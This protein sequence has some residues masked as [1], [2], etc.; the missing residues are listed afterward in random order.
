MARNIEIRLIRRRLRGAYI[1]T[2]VSISLVLFILGIMGLLILNARKLSNYVKENIGFSVILNDNSKEADVKALQKNLDAA[3][4]VKSTEY[5]S[6]EKA[7]EDLQ[8]ELDE[9]FI[10]FLGFNPLL[11]SINVHLFAD[12]ANPD[13][14]KSIEKNFQ[15]YPQ[16]KEV[17]YQKNLLHLINENVR[18]I[19]MILLLF[20]TLLFIISFTLINNT[21]RLVVYSKRFII[22]TMRLVGATSGFIRKPFIIRGVLQGLLGAILAFSM[23]LAFIF[24]ANNEM[25]DISSLIDGQII[26]ILFFLVII[27]GIL[28]TGISTYFAVNRYIK[29]NTDE[30]YY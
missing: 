25:K 19:S 8:A 15:Q 2:I 23:L 29:I 24:F 1:T 4:F 21:I 30:L 9:D 26:I 16:V 10:Q 28:I 12:Y 14:L 13:S 6:K 3:N 11:A 20:S 17:F 27:F 5:I 7:A 22:N 18:K